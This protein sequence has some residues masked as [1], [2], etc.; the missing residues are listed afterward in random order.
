MNF[1]VHFTLT[2]IGSLLPTL[3]RTIIK[4]GIESHVLFIG[5][6]SKS[7]VRDLLR[8]PDAAILLSAHD[9]SPIPVIEIPA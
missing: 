9:G 4:L 6:L 1:R 7:R 2:G 3:Q 5:L 8:Q